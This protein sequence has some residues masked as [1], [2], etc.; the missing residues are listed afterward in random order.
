[1]NKTSLQDYVGIYHNVLDSKLCKNLVID[2]DNFEWE[3]FSWTDSQ[4]KTAT[5]EFTKQCDTCEKIFPKYKLQIN[6]VIEN[7]IESYKKSYIG[8]I[9][10]AGFSP[11]KLNRYSVDSSLPRHIDHISSLFDGQKRGIPIL[12]IVG[13]FND[14]FEGGNF[15]LW[16]DF[17]VPMKQ[18]T[19][20]IFPSNFLYPHRVSKIVKG[21]RYSFANWVW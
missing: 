7:C 16:E 3:N 18:G 17:V 19:I 11:I 6:P 10:F 9:S 20:I 1:M 21:I 8:P 5:M 2:S 15:I 12:S 4:Y 14:D 13:L